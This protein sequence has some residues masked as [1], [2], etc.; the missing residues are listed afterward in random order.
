MSFISK[1]EREE[2]HLLKRA[3]GCARPAELSPHQNGEEVPVD[4]IP[5]VMLVD[6][7]S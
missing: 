3:Q 4:H 6:C 5:F 7:S 1:R 2:G